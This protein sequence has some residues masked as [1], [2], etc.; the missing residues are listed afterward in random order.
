MPVVPAGFF[1]VMFAWLFRFPHLLIDHFAPASFVFPAYLIT[2]SVH[3]PVKS[4]RFVAAESQGA[5]G[6]GAH[7]A[8]SWH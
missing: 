5:Y 7:A 8:G 1:A 4:S 2:W 6:G 3:V